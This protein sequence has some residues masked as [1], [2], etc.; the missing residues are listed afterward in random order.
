MF[1]CD[2]S[3]FGITTEAFS[4]KGQLV[5][6]ENSFAEG[7]NHQ[8][9]FRAYLRLFDP[10]KEVALIYH[11]S[12]EGS[13]DIPILRAVPNQRVIKWIAGAT[14]GAVDNFVIYWDKTVVDDW[15]GTGLTA[16]FTWQPTSEVI[17]DLYLQDVLDHVDWMGPMLSQLKKGLKN[18]YIFR[19]RPRRAHYEESVFWGDVVLP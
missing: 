3:V 9:Y 17:E 18:D 7:F 12:R 1:S 15:M 10:D 5:F 6:V 4:Q 11:F 14:E 19:K 16:E 2:L 8:Q 13:T